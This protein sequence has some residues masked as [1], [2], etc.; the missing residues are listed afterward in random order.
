MSDNNCEYSIYGYYNCNNTEA[1]NNLK[2]KNIKKI[3]KKTDIYT[4]PLMPINSSGNI[5][6]GPFHAIWGCGKKCPGHFVDN[7][8]KCV[9]KCQE[10]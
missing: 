3:S 10:K 5:K 2:K 8:C 1:F 4:C 7:V 6:N 9:F